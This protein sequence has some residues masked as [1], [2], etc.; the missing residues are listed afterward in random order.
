MQL[1][2]FQ[3]LSTWEDFEDGCEAT[4]EKKHFHEDSGGVINLRHHERIEYVNRIRHCGLGGLEYYDNMFL[5]V[6][7]RFIVVNTKTGNLFGGGQRCEG[8][9]V[10]DL[11]NDN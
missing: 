5:S 11:E 8:L 9:F 7:E 10:I 4:I 1:L 6:N 2:C 3:I